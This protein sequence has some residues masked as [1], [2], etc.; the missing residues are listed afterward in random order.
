MNARFT[1]SEIVLERRAL[2]GGSRLVLVHGGVDMEPT[3]DTF[4]SL[5]TAT[6]AGFEMFSGDDRGIEA[7]IAAVGVLEDDPAFN[8]GFGSVLTRA[9]TVETDGAVS[10]GWL[11]RSVGVGAAPGLRR[12]AALAYRLLQEEDVVLLVGAQASDYARSRGIPIEDLVVDEQKTALDA[13]TA[14]PT[15]SVFTGRAV[16]SETVGS[17]AINGL[18][19]VSAASSTGGLVGKLP[20]RV[21]DACIRGAGYWTDRRFGVLCSG[22]G[23]ATMNRQLASSLAALASRIGLA[24]AMEETLLQLAGAENAVC[25]IVAVDAEQNE[26][27]TAHNG[28]SFPVVARTA[29]E[30]FRLGDPRAGTR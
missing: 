8:S 28:S 18:G 21:G 12:P 24:P 27:V 14:D 11:G 6:L 26:V 19:R 22:S 15:R 2:P 13:I 1:T 9:G 29:T 20:G 7:A 25:A 5:E 16:P 4:D 17:L 30:V 23:E 10:D 3:Q